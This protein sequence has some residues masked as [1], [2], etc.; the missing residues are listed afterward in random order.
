M[1][2]VEQYFFNHIKNLSK[3]NCKECVYR[4]QCRENVEYYRNICIIVGK[5]FDKIM[6]EFWVSHPDLKDNA[7]K[8]IEEIKS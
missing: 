8:E 4:L 2:K 6:F 5:A 1:S 7:M 3:A